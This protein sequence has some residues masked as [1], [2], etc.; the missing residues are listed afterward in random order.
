MAGTTKLGT[1][2]AA[3]PLDK[4]FPRSQSLASLASN[5]AHTATIPSSPLKN[6][7]TLPKA[8]NCEHVSER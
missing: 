6:P 3:D 2:R 1:P 7:V 8:K 5:V 4:T